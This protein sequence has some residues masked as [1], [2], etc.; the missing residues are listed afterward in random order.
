MPG[1]VTLDEGYAFAGSNAYKATEL[2]SV[3]CL[4]HQLEE[5]FLTAIKNDSKVLQ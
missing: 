5:E 1:W 3:H 2:T 4:I